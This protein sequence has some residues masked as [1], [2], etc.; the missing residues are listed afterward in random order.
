MPVKFAPVCV[1]ESAMAVDG[2]GSDLLAESFS[3][4][5]KI[6]ARNMIE[7]AVIKFCIILSLQNDL[8]TDNSIGQFV[9]KFITVEY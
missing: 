9:Y 8:I 5:F 1:I 3:Q 4:E 6:I 2:F 7:I